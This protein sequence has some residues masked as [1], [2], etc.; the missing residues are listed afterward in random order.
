M[1]PFLL[2]S[3]DQ[4]S[5]KM[6][7]MDNMLA[8]LFV[9]ALG[10]AVVVFIWYSIVSQ[11]SADVEPAKM[12]PIC[13]C[14]GECDCVDDAWAYWEANSEKNENSNE[15]DRGRVCGCRRTCTRHS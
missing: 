8:G 4:R 15:E 13:H 5:G 7:D 3:V 9:A 11:E 6:S 12:C 1:G 10:L 2:L 14:E